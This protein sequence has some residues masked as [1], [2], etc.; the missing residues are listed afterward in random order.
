MDYSPLTLFQTEDDGATEGYLCA[1]GQP[2]RSVAVNDPAD[3]ALAKGFKFS[4]NDL[5][6]LHRLRLSPHRLTESRKAFPS[7]VRVGANEHHAILVGDM[8]IEEGKVAGCCGLVET[9]REFPKFVRVLH[10][11]RATPFDCN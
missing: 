5:H 2:E 7:F 9:L 8:P 4:R 11:R 10:S 1:I 3:V 6:P